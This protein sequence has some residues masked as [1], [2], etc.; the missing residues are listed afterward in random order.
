MARRTSEGLLRSQPD[1]RLVTLMRSGDVAVFAAIVD[2][3][4]PE[5]L[6]HAQRLTHDG[7][8]EDIVQQA[9]L[10][11]F[12]AFQSGA[13]VRHLRGWL[14][15]ILRNA[16]IKAQAPL[17]APLDDGAVVSESLEDLVQRRATARAVLSE[18]SGLPGR[19]RDALVN[20]ALL[21][22]PRAQVARRMGLSEGAVRQ[23]VHRGRLSV[24][25]AVTALVPYP[26]ARLAGAVQ[27]GAGAAPDAVAPGG[28]LSGGGALAK[29][30]AL[31]ASGLLA[32][33]IAGGDGS[34]GEHPRHR[35]QAPVARIQRSSVAP[36][37]VTPALPGP[38]IG[39]AAERVVPVRDQHGEHS[40]D[41]RGRL[42]TNGLGERGGSRHGGGD[43]SR[44]SGRR[45][46]TDDAGRGEQ[47]PTTSSSSDTGSSSGG[48][49]SSPGG[50]SS[51]PDGGSSSPDGGSSTPGGGSSSPG[52]GS[53]GG[54]G[55]RTD[56][57]GSGGGGSSKDGGG[58]GGGSSTD[59][60][61]SG[62]GSSSDGPS[63][64]SGGRS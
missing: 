8:A 11:A 42:R 17:E 24:R 13:R 2:R 35:T 1:E 53:S 50:G 20:S 61:G 37:T 38:A 4:E 6:A 45:E 57:G 15:Q 21:G 48:G 47:G 30:G 41:P 52:G 27:A 58:S 36:T 5:L 39:G 16:V 29:V 51:T 32:S 26:L 28:L 54:G 9:F 40:T 23:L 7:G 25:R 46:T 33:G 44:G 22:L 31:I 56:G 10:N 19:Q 18:L 63:P 60:G 34:H 62:G 49:S 3:Y 14:H 55:T 12:V 43:R 64:G 59:G